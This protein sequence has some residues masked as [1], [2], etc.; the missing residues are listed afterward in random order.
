MASQIEY[1]KHKAAAEARA[2]L[3]A[4]FTLYEKTSTHQARLFEAEGGEVVPQQADL[5]R[6]EAYPKLISDLAGDVALRQIFARLRAEWIFPEN[7][8][9]VGGGGGVDFPKRLA[10][11][12]PFAA[13]ID[14]ADFDAGLLTDP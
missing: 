1:R 8:L 9:E 5:A 2:R 6:S 10:R 12:R 14:L 11:V 13:R 4:I 7:L 3:A